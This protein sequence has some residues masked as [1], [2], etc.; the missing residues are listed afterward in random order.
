MLVTK[1]LAPLLHESKNCNS[2]P[3]EKS[4][5]DGENS[6]LLLFRQHR[7][8]LKT[9]LVLFFDPQKFLTSWRVKA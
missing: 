6:Y 9:R 2:G 3:T 8:S 1:I 5:A 4:G 7:E